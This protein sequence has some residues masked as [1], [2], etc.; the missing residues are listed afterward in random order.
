M[1]HIDTPDAIPREISS[2][3]E[4]DKRLG[5]HAAGGIGLFHP[6]DTT[7]VR[8]VDGGRPNQR[9][10]DRND[11]PESNRSQISVLSGSDNLLI[12]HIHTRHNNSRRQ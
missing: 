12:A 9:L 6:A 3:T 10:I 8:I 1:H 11:S 4:S 5:D 2:R 7:W